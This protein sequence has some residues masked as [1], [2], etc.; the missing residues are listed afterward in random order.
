M[1]K[2]VKYKLG[3][4]LAAALLLEVLLWAIFAAVVFVVMDTVPGLRMEAPHRWVLFLS[5]PVVFAFFM[6][7]RASNNN[8]LESFA[9]LDL[10][11][12]LVQDISNV[13][14]AV[15]YLLWRLAAAFLISALINPQL[16][17]KMAEAKV[18]GIE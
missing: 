12:A 16:G 4:I 17:S 1:K 2:T 10:L 13:N 5:G 14:T 11:C 8:R 3:Y 7:S 18:S 15:K 9:E 6:W